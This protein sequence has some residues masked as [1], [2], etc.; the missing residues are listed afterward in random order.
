M[1]FLN[2]CQENNDTKAK[3]IAK[4]VSAWKD[5]RK[6]IENNAWQENKKD[7]GLWQIN[8]ESNHE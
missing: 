5:K 1:F 8:K 3:K 2:A 7:I 4:G 6:K